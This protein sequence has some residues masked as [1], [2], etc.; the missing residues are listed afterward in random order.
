MPLLPLSADLSVN[1][2]MM[3]AVNFWNFVAG[4]SG[5]KVLLL[6]L[7]FPWINLWV[8]V[9]TVLFGVSGFDPCIYEVAPETSYS[10]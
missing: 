4:A 9:G 3:G 5:G 1:L 8:T 7:W 6:M 10:L 2:S